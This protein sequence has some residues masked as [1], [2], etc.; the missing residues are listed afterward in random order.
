MD[1]AHTAHFY[2]S[3]ETQA[4]AMETSVI[5]HGNM[6]WMSMVEVNGF[7]ASKG[8]CTY[9]VLIHTLYTLT[10]LANIFV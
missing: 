9:K 5:H 6:T 1:S 2:F 7:V 4:I 10:D 8:A 3:T